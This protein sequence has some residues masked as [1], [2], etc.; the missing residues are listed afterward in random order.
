MVRGDTGYC[1]VA[2][3]IVRMW[4]PGWAP[5][6]RVSFYHVSPCP[7][8]NCPIFKIEIINITFM[9][10]SWNVNKVSKARTMPRQSTF[11]IKLAKSQWGENSKYSK[12]KGINGY[13]KWKSIRVQKIPSDLTW[14]SCCHL[15]LQEC[16][17]KWDREEKADRLQELIVFPHNFFGGKKI[18]K[19]VQEAFL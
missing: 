10:F 11:S 8:A 12:T 19:D 7:R 3:T 1:V 14:L 16:N 5:A 13:K 2:I 15:K 9:R 4:V 18:F 17:L 6:I